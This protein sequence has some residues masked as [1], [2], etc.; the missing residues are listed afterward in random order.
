MDRPGPWLCDGAH[1]AV[2]H[3]EMPDEGTSIPPQGS[4]TSEVS[5][6]AAEGRDRTSDHRDLASDQSDRTSDDRDLTAERRDRRSEG[7]DRSAEERDRVHGRLGTE[8]TTNPGGPERREQNLGRRKSDASAEWGRASAASDRIEAAS[9]RADAASD[10]EAS[11]AGRQRGAEDRTQASDDRDAA[12]L[13]RDASALDR[14]ASSTDELTGSYRRGAGLVELER[15]M[16]RAQ[17]TKHPFM[18]A[19]VD[20]DGLKA[21]NDSLGHAAGD[22]LLRDVVDCLRANLR[23]YDLLVRFGGDEFVCALTDLGASEATARFERINT[24]LDE[25]YKAS[26]TVGFAEMKAG[27]SLARLIARADEAL[28]EKRP[29]SAR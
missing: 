3:G 6:Q 13:D 12:S 14:K 1:R 7:R 28:Y 25:S 8:A 19:F 9:D 23:S 11:S 4:D 20:V 22:Q 29:P 18:L 15:E 27:D 2:H 26:I 5:D 21:V 16:I 10:R 17:R 24:T